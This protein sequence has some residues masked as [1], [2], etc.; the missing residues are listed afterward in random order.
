MSSAG[1]AS[2]VHARSAWRLLTR[3]RPCAVAAAVVLLLP[4]PLR[5]AEGVP[6]DLADVL[7]ASL[8]GS[9]LMSDC[10]QFEAA[11]QALMMLSSKAAQPLVPC[12]ERMLADSVLRK[13]LKEDADQGCGVLIAVLVG[14]GREKVA[15]SQ[16]LQESVSK[17]RRA[18][19]QG[20]GQAQAQV[21][22]WRRCRWAQCAGAC[23][24]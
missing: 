13:V 2:V 5:P 24:W 17:V 8:A 15:L 12:F 23:A 7:A 20:Q 11:A 1:R 14:L 6:T 18:L 9:S 19:G 22:R 4:L 21:Q 10:A 16:K 3:T